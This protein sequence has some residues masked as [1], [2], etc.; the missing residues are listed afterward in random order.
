MTFCHS[1]EFTNILGVDWGTEIQ[2]SHLAKE[3]IFGRMELGTDEDDCD[4][5]NVAH[6]SNEIDQEKQ[7]W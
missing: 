4:K 7:H 1:R 2:E 5:P 3:N 6:P